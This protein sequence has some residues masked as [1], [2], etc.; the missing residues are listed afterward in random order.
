ME[1]VKVI[2]KLEKVFEVACNQFIEMKYTSDCSLTELKEL[3]A[4]IINARKNIE[5]EVQQAKTHVHNT[6]H[7]YIA[8]HILKLVKRKG[9]D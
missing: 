6:K 3:G 7:S 2:E 8:K 1:N 5:H 9:R 4:T